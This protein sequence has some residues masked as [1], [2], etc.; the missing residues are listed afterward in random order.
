[1]LRGFN[2]STYILIRIWNWISSITLRHS[3]SLEMPIKSVNPTEKWIT[4]HMETKCFLIDTHL[5]H[6]NKQ[7]YHKRKNSSPAHV[8]N[9]RANLI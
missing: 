1:M 5:G 6:K 7:F 8:Y 4:H 3:R 9:R 2:T